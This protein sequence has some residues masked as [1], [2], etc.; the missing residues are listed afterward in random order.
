MGA[1][2]KLRATSAP[3][4]GSIAAATLK[5]GSSFFRH[6]GELRELPTTFYRRE[7]LP[8]GADIAGPALIFQ[9]D[10]TPLLPPGSVAHVDASGSLLVRV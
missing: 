7:M 9:K 1:L 8:V 6:D 10:S 2:P 5:V 4:G 3:A